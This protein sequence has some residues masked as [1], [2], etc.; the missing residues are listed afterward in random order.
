M[1]EMGDDFAALRKMSQ[2]KRAL[3]REQSPKILERA[4]LLFMAHNN[5]AHLVVE[6]ENEI[7]DFWPGTGKWIIRVTQQDGRGVRNLI[8]ALS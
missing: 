5:G 4:G 3:N 1:S 2:D 7:A 8:K 6:G